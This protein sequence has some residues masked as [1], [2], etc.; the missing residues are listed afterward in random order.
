MRVEGYGSVPRNEPVA[1]VLE[2]S[3]RPPLTGQREIGVT[4][5]IQVRE[6]RAAHQAQL[7][8]ALRKA[9]RFAIVAQ[10]LRGSRFGIAASPDTAAH[11][12]VQVAVAIHVCKRE[13]TGG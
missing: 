6:D 1:L 4:V 2:N 8:K 11:K 5:S 13:W 3:N 10:Q 12:E 7:W 9:E